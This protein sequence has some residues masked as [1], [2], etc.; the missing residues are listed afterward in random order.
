MVLDSAAAS[1]L[2]QYSFQLVTCNHFSE[3][4][5][6]NAQGS[7]GRMYGVPKDKDNIFLVYNK[8][9]F[10]AAD[11]VGVFGGVGVADGL[12]AVPLGYV[13]NL[14]LDG[15]PRRKL[16]LGRPDRRLRPDLRQDRKVRLLMT[17]RAMSRV[18]PWA[19]VE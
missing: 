12:H 13:P 19:A 11:H 17:S 16:D 14:E 6:G 5:I 2:V 3:I 4:S 7:N 1:S 15:L 18:L 8:E 10:D 9:M